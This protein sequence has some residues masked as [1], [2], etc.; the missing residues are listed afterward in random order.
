M[1]NEESYKNESAL[2]DGCLS[3]SSAAYRYLVEHYKD[4][5]F[6]T[7]I[8]F[9]HSEADA[10]DITQEVFIEVFRSVKKFRKESGLSTWIYRIAVNKSINYHRIKRRRKIISFFDLNDIGEPVIKDEQFASNDSGPDSAIENREHSVVIKSAIDSLPKNQKTAFI[11]SKYDNLS[12]Q[13]VASVMKV[14][15]S[16]VESLVFRARRTLQTKLYSYYKKNM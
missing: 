8:G 16:S 7:V 11:L 3:G 1:G 15:V 9:V 4:K 2:L 12:Y 5:V 13:E 14:S 10:E 6:R